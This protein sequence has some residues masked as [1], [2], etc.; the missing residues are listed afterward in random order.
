MGAHAIVFFKTNEKGMRL[1]TNK[2]WVQFDKKSSE[3][4]SWVCMLQKKK[5]KV[6]QKFVE[7]Y[8]SQFLVAVLS[9]N[10]SKSNRATKK[11]Q[12]SCMMEQAID[13]G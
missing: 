1:F 3:Q 8:H 13:R 7:I 11:I 12:E 9:K 4:T 10:S 5:K 6:S 2:D